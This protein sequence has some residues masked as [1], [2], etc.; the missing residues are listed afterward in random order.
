MFCTSNGALQSVLSHGNGRWIM[1]I[2]WTYDDAIKIA[3]ET[4][5]ENA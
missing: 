2:Q 5:S 4:I 3:G 1:W